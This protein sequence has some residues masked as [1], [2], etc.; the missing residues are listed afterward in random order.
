MVESSG[1]TKNISICRPRSLR[2]MPR[3]YGHDGDEEDYYN[4]D[5]G[6]RWLK[7][8]AAMAVLGLY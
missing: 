7:R 1:N 6:N 5:Y 8:F 2:F 4:N 3:Q